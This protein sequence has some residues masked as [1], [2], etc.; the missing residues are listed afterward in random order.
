[1][2]ATFYHKT[3]QYSHDLILQ[4]FNTASSVVDKWEKGFFALAQYYDHLITEMRKETSNVKGDGKVLDRY[5]LDLVP[6]ACTNYG[7]AIRS[8]HTYIYQS[9]ARLTTLWFDSY[10][11]KLQPP[12][13][14]KSRVEQV[15]VGLERVIQ[16]LANTKVIPA[17]WLIMY[18]QLMSRVCT[19]SKQVWSHLRQIIVR[20]S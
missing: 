4:R 15:I 18:S 10:T 13:I 2:P 5:A 7:L 11:S 9:L 17:Y 16:C 12:S 8:G 3:G 6:S 14:P 19:P 20:V 1:M